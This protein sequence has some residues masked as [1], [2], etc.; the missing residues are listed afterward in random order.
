MKAVVDPLRVERLAELLRGLAEQPGGLRAGHESLCVDGS[1]DGG[2][3]V[4]RIGRYAFRRR[5]RRPRLVG[6]AN[7][8]QPFRPNRAHPLVPVGI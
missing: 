7:K 5:L 1:R 8:V 3:E 6:H 4:E 2:V